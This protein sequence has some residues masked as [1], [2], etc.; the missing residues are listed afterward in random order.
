M[1]LG[2]SG[3]SGYIMPVFV[4]CG[5]AA[6]TTKDNHEVS[7]LGESVAN[8]HC[9]TDTIYAVGHISS[10]HMNPTVTLAFATVGH[11]PWA[12]VPN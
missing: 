10:A 2:G 3:N 4:T 11:F 8:G 7:H 1:Q 9:L 12:Q 5:A 6:L